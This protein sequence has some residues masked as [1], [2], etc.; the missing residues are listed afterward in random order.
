MRCS[1]ARKLI[2]LYVAPGHSWLRPEDRRAL[3]AHMAVCE[4]C[5]QDCRESLELIAIL[6]ACWQISEDTAALLRQGPRG[7]STRIIRLFG[8]SRRAGVCVAAACL[9]LVAFGAWAFSHRAAPSP[10]A[11]R[12]IARAREDVPLSIESADGGR[13]ASGTIV[14]TL[15]DETKRLVLNGRH[16]VVMNAGVRLSIEPLVEM[17]QTGCLVNLALGEIYVHVEHDGLPF[18]VRTAH[19]RAVVTG[20]IFDVKT[21]EA[22]TTLVVTAGSVRFESQAGA[23][24]VTAGQQSR[25]SSAS[26]LPGVPAPCDAATLTAWATSNATPAEP[27]AGLAVSGDL[28]LNE[29]ALLPLAEVRTDAGRIDYAEWV[30]QKRE[31]FRQQ[32]PWVFELGEALAREGVEVDYPELLLRSGEIRQFRYPQEMNQRIPTFDP[33]TLLTLAQTFGR[34]RSWLVSQGTYGSRQ[35]TARP[36][37]E[38]EQPPGGIAPGFRQWAQSFDNRTHAGDGRVDEMTLLLSSRV[39]VYLTNTRTLAALIIRQDPESNRPG[40][41]ADKILHLLDAQLRALADCSRRLHELSA[42]G[43][44]ADPCDCSDRVNRLIETILRIGDSEKQ[45]RQIESGLP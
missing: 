16:E 3:E 12:L 5:R 34:D 35:G 19:A 41:G 44:K 30:E 6:P 27:T 17:G 4:P 21:T 8:A 9:A 45:V 43:A 13:V 28:G 7:A 22:G 39:C 20:T 31:W 40:T 1:K 38:P 36:R 18:V 33:D 42:P 24:Q 25:L 10:R 14:Q 26:R 37:R 29:L 15:A 2:S 11:G 32:F 23:V